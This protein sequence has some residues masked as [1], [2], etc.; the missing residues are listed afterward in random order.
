MTLDNLAVRHKK[1]G[2]GTVVKTDG[3]YMT[4]HFESADKVFVYPDAFEKFLTL[5]DGTVCSEILSDIE[6]EQNRKMQIENAKAQENLR[7]MQLGIVIPG[8]E[9]V[10]DE[11]GEDG[12]QPDHTEIEE[13]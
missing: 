4:V 13:T 8:K 11:K 5:A 3:K 7:A 10:S 2:V 12:Y 9:N 6:A 1:F